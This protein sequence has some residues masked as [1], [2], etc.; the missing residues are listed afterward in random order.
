M[1]LQYNN[2]IPEICGTGAEKKMKRV[3]YISK[4]YRLIKRIN[5]K[6]DNNSEM[7]R[8]EENIQLD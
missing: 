5:D 6:S 2:N 7:T 4:I 1:V 8:K 3:K